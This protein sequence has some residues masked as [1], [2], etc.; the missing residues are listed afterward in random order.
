MTT[1]ARVL[2]GTGFADSRNHDSLPAVM[3]RASSL[4]MSRARRI[5][6]WAVAGLVCTPGLAHAHPGRAPE[7]HDLWTAWTL[8]P[9]VLGGGL[10]AAWV[11]GRGVRAAR[12]HAPRA[13]L[14]ALAQVCCYAG[15]WI[16][17]LLALVSPVDAVSAALF[18]AHMLQHLLLMMVAAPLFVLGDPMT[19]ALWALPVRRRRAVAAWWRR[20]ALLRAGWRVLRAPLAAWTLHVV[21]LWLWHYPR[22]YDLA[23]R[24]EPVHLFEHATFFL[25]AL[26]FWWPVLRR[27]G[28][29]LRDGVAVLYLFGAAL[30]STLLGAALTLATRPLYTVHF[31]TT[32]AWGLTPLEDQQL[33]GLLMWVPAGFVYLAALVPP[34]IRALREPSAQRAPS[35]LAIAGVSARGTP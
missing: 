16:A 11:Y 19:A 35:S 12:R 3:R 15:A 5:G 14:M 29:R 8:A 27:R 6:V 34:V 1:V 23:L 21:V 26:L 2:G 31:G 20:A 13:R 24:D 4:M 7:P 32:W 17:L 28:R 33:A 10:T 9:V 18:S 22:F 25:T 30:Q